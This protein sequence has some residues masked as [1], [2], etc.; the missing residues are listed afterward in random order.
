[1]SQAT[2]R[3]NLRFTYRFRYGDGRVEELEIELDYETLGFVPQAREQ[4]PH[5]TALGFHQCPNCPL[6]ESTHPCCPIAR[7]LVPVVEMLRDRISHEECE[8]EVETA[9]RRYSRRT[10]LQHAA[11]S[12]IGIVNVTSG[13]PTLDKLR[14][15]VAT[16]L[17]FMTS[18]ESTYRMISTYLMSQYFLHKQGLGA[19]LA[20][21][22]F[23]DFLR[24][25]RDTNGAF[26]ERLH[27]LGVKD[28]SL[29]ALHSLNA[30]GEIVSLT[31]QEQD[32]ER[33]ERLFVSTW[34]RAAGPGSPEGAP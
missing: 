20:L 13:C 16:H 1:M 4:E 24:E 28:A 9:G 3:E 21:V 19:D 17:P 8:V 18:D 15:M 2:Q 33:W 34:G 32:L 10:S 11:G 6:Q 23:L 7:N 14:P 12:L 25:A 30:M 31:I 22:G 27:A 26:C 29:N 5:W